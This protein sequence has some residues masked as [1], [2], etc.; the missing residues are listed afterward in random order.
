MAKNIAWT[1][2][3]S[4]LAEKLLDFNEKRQELIAA[5][6]RVYG[7]LGME[8]PRYSENLHPEDV[9][10]FTVMANFS[11]RL[12]DERR[13][14]IMAAFKEEFGISADV[15]SE[16]EGLPI[17]SN[18]YPNFYPLGRDEAFNINMLWNLF[19]T[20]MKFKPE[21]SDDSDKA[22]MSLFDA[23]AGIEGNRWKI[24]FGLSYIRP[25]VFVSLDTKNRE[26]LISEHILP[27]KYDFKEVPTGQE[28][29]DICRI[30]KKYTVDK[31]VSLSQVSAA[32][33]R[34]AIASRALK[35]E[36]EKVKEQ[37]EVEVEAEP[38][39]GGPRFW[40]YSVPD[41]KQVRETF[42]D[43]GLMA[44][45]WGEIGSLKNYQT[46][47]G[48]RLAMV[49]E[50][51][52]KSFKQTSKMTWD[53]LN[54]LREGD[55]IFA[56]AGRT[57]IVGRGVVK[58]DYFYNPEAEPAYRHLRK[59]DWNAV[60]LWDS[61]VNFANKSLTD[62]TD[63]LEAAVIVSN[64]VDT[65]ES[66]APVREVA[67]PEVSEEQQPVEPEKVKVEADPNSVYLDEGEKELLMAALM[68]WRRIFLRGPIGTGKNFIARRLAVIS[69]CMP[70][71]IYEYDYR[72]DCFDVEDELGEISAKAELNADTPY[73][74]IVHESA[75]LNIS[76]FL[77]FNDVPS[78]LYIIL[79]QAGENSELDTPDVS[80][81]QHF[82][83]F[84]LS[85][86][87]ES[88][89]FRAW[90]A[91]QDCEELQKLAGLVVELNKELVLTG[92]SSYQ[93]GHGLFMREEKIDAMAVRLIA[94]CVIL[95]MLRSVWHDAPLRYEKW[96]A[97]FDY[98]I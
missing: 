3:Y 76:N 65:E 63:D 86:K 57:E 55:V 46:R 58:S 50:I 52:G 83:V 60:G 49:R 19:M 98:N 40:A 10:P 48:M 16:F 27:S 42:F 31:D 62:M 26:Y 41:D 47:E 68:R 72:N 4:E 90:M 75:L 73:F 7:S 6:I 25:D 17:V 93:I 70:Q 89:G 12:S 84:N 66:K 36:A 34:F 32:A 15:P 35:R 22:L 2:F 80:L 96:K 39:Y 92:L 43:D 95:P 54:T 24:T 37:E 56:K 81:K 5:L 30:M 9:D 11:K 88:E 91:A 1:V 61:P 87:L 79:T 82:A 21:R 45:G 85:P 23:V 64:T 59:V 13:M 74:V 18:A 77:M 38:V 51:G 14:S 28:Y 53:F 33:D 97:V 29:L 67:E 20:A 94:K 78:N 8:L 69:G 44:L 71:H